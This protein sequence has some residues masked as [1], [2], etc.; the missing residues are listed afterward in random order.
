[1]RI[2][3]T[4][5]YRAPCFVLGL[6]MLYG[7]DFMLRFVLIEGQTDDYAAYMGI[8]SPEFVADAGNKVSFAMASAVFPGLD[9]RRYRP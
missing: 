5:E 9:E 4:A 3:A 7:P 1:M 8:G 2:I 6:E